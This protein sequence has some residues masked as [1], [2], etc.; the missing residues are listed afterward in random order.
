MV[1]DLVSAGRTRTEVAVAGRQP[2]AART[3]LAGVDIAR[4]L[5]VLGMY[6]VHV[7]PHPRFGGAGSWYAPFEGRSSALFAVLAGVSLAL[8][9]GGARPVHGI[10]LRRTRVKVGTRA[11]LLFVI[12]LGL[13]SMNTGI[14]VILP[15]YG[16]FFLCALPLLHLRA[17][18]LAVVAAALA[19]AGPVLSFLLRSWLLPKDGP[20]QLI[21]VGLGSFASLPGLWD[22]LLALVLTG[23][24]PALTWLPFV[25]AGMA[26]GR[27]DLRRTRIWGWLGAAGL[28]LLFV[29]YFGSWVALT[30]H[31]MDGLT[32]SVEEAAV[33]LGQ[34]P[35]HYLHDEQ[36]FL[37]GTVP[38]TAW[39]WLL[40]AMPHS[41]TAFDVLGSTGAALAVLGLC[42]ALGHLVPRVLYPLGSV[43]TMAL[44]AYAGHL[45]MIAI[46]WGKRIPVGGP[47]LTWF[48]VVTLAAATLWR[49]FLGRGP[50]E[51]VLHT[52]ARIA[53]DHVGYG[54][55]AAHR[56]PRAPRFNGLTRVG[57]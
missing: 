15:Y 23:T 21:D 22:G 24:F 40:V 52:A 14:L 3:R 39:D 17:R 6:A 28:G 57:R 5:A 45:A 16:I 54:S 56:A 9:S 18:T 19:V 11:L 38:T 26:V 47:T 20:H 53:A 50:L 49:W 12:G 35:A 42:L 31:G 36:W 37:Y 4:G 13:A 44:T 8:L 34:T 2:P 46:L 33:R 29:G 32:G 41:G 51:R 10:A 43:G 7:G 27:L 55:R 1:A 30:W 25:Y 48:V